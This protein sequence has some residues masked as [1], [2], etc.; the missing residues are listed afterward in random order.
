MDK[1]HITTPIQTLERLFR[2]FA[3]FE[4]PTLKCARVWVHSS[5]KFV[6]IISVRKCVMITIISVLLMAVRVFSPPSSSFS[7][8]RKPA[9]LER[10]RITA[11]LSI[12]TADLRLW[13]DSSA[14]SCGCTVKWWTATARLPWNSPSFPPLWRSSRRSGGQSPGASAAG[15]EGTRYPS[16]PPW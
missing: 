11:H 6:R 15:R 7:S 1:I 14:W 4:I 3:Y 8:H 5:A 2:T 12:N 10:Y 13:S 16:F 9:H